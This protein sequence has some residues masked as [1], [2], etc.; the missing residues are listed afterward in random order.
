MSTVSFGVKESRTP[1]SFIHVLQDW[2][3]RFACRIGLGDLEGCLSGAK[4]RDGRPGPLIDDV[5]PKV[6]LAPLLLGT[7]T[8]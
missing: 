8:S 7:L 1:L 6:S 4:R 3:E 2:M 5:A